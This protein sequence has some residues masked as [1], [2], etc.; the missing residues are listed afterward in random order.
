MKIINSLDGDLQ[1][2]AEMVGTLL[3]QGVESRSVDGNLQLVRK[4]GFGSE[5]YAVTLFKGVEDRTIDRYERIHSV[6]I[7]ETYRDVLHVLNGASVFGLNLYGVPSSMTKDPPLLDRSAVQPLDI[8]TANAR[9]RFGFTNDESLF[10]I[11]GAPWTPEE[12]V[13]YFLT[14]DSG[15]ASIRKHNAINASWDGLQ[16]FLGEEIDRAQQVYREIETLLAD[17]RNRIRTPE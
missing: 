1:P 3:S 13:A 5:A 14:V 11:G 16:T 4:P 15:V 6:N 17:S 8:A 12:N 2:I 10:Q 9:W 7:P